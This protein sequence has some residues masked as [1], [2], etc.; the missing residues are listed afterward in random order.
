VNSIRIA[1]CLY[2]LKGAS[3]GQVEDHISLVLVGIDEALNRTGGVLITSVG[4]I[5]VAHVVQAINSRTPVD[6]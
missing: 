2:D 3:R 5:L 4:P 1:L 6:G